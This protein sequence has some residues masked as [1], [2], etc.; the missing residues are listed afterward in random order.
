MNRKNLFIALSAFILLALGTQKSFTQCYEL[1]WSEEFNYTGFPDSKTWNMEVGDNDGANNEK[2]W[3]TQN[4]SDN[5]YVDSGRMVIRALKESMGGQAYTSARIN[6][7][8]KVDFSYGKVEARLKL[9]YGQG[10]WPAFWMLG[11][12]FGQV[13]WPKCGEFDIME[14]IGGIDP[15][16]RTTYG[17]NHWAN[18][19]G[20]HAYKGGSKTLPA[21]NKFADD[22]HLFS[23]TWDKTKAVW[24]LDGVQFYTMNITAADMTEFHQNYFIILNLAVGGDWP[25]YPNAT[26]VFPQK[27]EVDYVRV[28]QLLNKDTIEGK[29]SVLTKEK[30]LSYSITPVEGREYS[31]TVP[32][33]VSLVS[34]PDS[35]AVLVDWGCEGGDIVCNVTTSCSSEYVFTKKVQVAA[36]VIQGPLFFGQAAGNLFFFVPEMTETEYLWEIP[37]G[38]S[39][40]AGD[41]SSATEVSWGADPGIVQLQISNSCGTSDISKKIFKYAKYPYPDPESPFIVPGIINSTDYDYGGQGIAYYDNSTGNQGT[42]PRKDER[43]DTEY[44]SLFP[45]VGWI[46]TGE[47]LEYTIKVPE[48]GYYRIELKVATQNTTNFGPVRVLV[49]GEKRVNDIALTSTGSWTNFVSVSQRLLL[50]NASDTVLRIHAVNGGFN[51]GPITLSPDNTVSVEKFASAEGSIHLYPNPV[52]DI[53]HIF[54]SLKKSGDVQL[55]IMNISGKTL[56]ESILKSMPAGEQNMSFSDGIKVLGHGLYILEV[57]TPDEIF[58]LKFLKD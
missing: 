52:N 18:A 46:T 50:L 16:D 9:P 36:P 21:G 24:Y 35:N 6:T 22:Y 15:R 48:T 53:L 28:Y 26:T 38:G 33:G 41:T 40:I 29:D 11:A 2:Q 4:D 30:S 32:A 34:K 23:Y 14:M 20:A 8:G 58:Y 45:N 43:V 12:S 27:F 10:I 37:E 47:W 44:Q 39:F 3:Y 55:R 5:C 13:G 42:G 57:S 17:T 31:W 19:S 25:G 56:S 51:L 54:L 7:R 1:I 49:N